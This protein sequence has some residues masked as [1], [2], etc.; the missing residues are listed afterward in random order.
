MA[1]IIGFGGTGTLNFNGGGATTFP[2]RN[3]SVSFE[4]ASLDV[5][6]ITDFR[7]KR[8]PGRI[9]RTAT[10]EMLAQDSTTDNNLRTHIYPTSLADAVNRSVVLTYTDQGSIAYTI[11]GHITSASRTDDGT[12]PGIWSLSLDE[13]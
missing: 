13:A 6:T 8:A 5:T 2:V 12:G 1:T 4:R 10:F 7:E 9:R 3:V 11:T